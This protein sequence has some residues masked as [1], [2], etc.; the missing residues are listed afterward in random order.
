VNSALSSNLIVRRR[1]RVAVSILV[2][3]AVGLA[4]TFAIPAYF[5]IHQLGWSFNVR[6]AIWL[7]TLGLINSFQI[8]LPAA[9]F[10][11]VCAYYYCYSKLGAWKQS[12]QT[13]APIRP[14]PGWKIF[15]A[16]MVSYLVIAAIIAGAAAWDSYR[17]NYVC[18]PD[19]HIIQSEA[20]AIKQGQ[21]RIFKAHYGTHDTPGYVDEKPGVAD[22]SQPDCCAVKR[23]LTMT[24]VI[25]WDVS[26]DG[27]TI[28]EPKK[29]HVSALMRLSNCGVVF[30]DSYIFADPIR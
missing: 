30:D 9:P 11:A 23:T 17:L 10:A 18:G 8:W 12:G 27:E 6:D 26:L 29:R 20:D 4:V 3:I 14:K 16:T 24:S 7:I 15:R 22:F 1:I 19:D 2:A 21:R 13:A 28:G 5:L 25:Q